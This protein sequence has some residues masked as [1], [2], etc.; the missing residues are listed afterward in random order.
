[1]TAANGETK[2]GYHVY[3]GCALAP[4][5]LPHSLRPSARGCVRLDMV[6]AGGSTG[7]YHTKMEACKTWRDV[8][9]EKLGAPASKF[10]LKP[11]SQF[12]I[13]KTWK[14]GAKSA[15]F[16]ASYSP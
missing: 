15:A 4:W 5:E 16:N 14:F 2:A 9:L 10:F 8:S 7:P 1:M 3:A 12:W 11:F 6:P 13:P